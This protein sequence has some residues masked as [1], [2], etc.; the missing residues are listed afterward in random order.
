MATNV[1]QDIL[2]ENFEEDK[3]AQLWK[4]GKPDAEGYLTLT[5]E[6]LQNLPNLTWVITATSESDLKIKGKNSI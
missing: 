5:S 6:L 1:N 2:E 4:T 3:A